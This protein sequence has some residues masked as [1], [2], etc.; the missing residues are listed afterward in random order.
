MPRVNLPALPTGI[1]RRTFSVMIL[2]L[3]ALLMA[4][5]A[6][7]LPSPETS[8]VE[9]APN[10]GQPLA[11]ADFLLIRE[12]ARHPAMRGANFA[13]FDIHVYVHRRVRTVAF[14]ER[15]GGFVER[16]TPNGTAIIVPPRDP[17]CRSITFEMAPDGTV[18]RVIRTRH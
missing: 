8:H 12:A 6:Q 9:R 13:C 14:I 11:G 17:N 15:R 4:V 10:L 5:A 1:E 16:Q 7:T 3:P 18:M 2:A